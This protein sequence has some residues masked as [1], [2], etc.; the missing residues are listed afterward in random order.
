MPFKSCVLTSEPHHLYYWTI[1]VVN[2]IPPSDVESNEILVMVY[3]KMP[4]SP[5]MYSSTQKGIFQA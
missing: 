4:G 5:M 2:A 1:T 3:Q